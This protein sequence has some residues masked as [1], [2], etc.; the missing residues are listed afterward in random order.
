MLLHHQFGRTP[1]GAH[2]VGELPGVGHRRRQAHQPNVGRGVDDHLL[3]HRPPG[4]VLQI[5]HLVQHHRLHF[6]QVVPHVDHV[7]QHF[8]GHHHHR[9]APV[10]RVVP[11]EQTHPFASVNPAQ[12]AEFLVGQGFDGSGVK[13]PPAPAQAH[14]HRPFRHQS[15]ARP[16]G[17]RHHHRRPPFHRLQSRCLKRIGR[18]G[19]GIQKSGQAAAV[20]F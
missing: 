4:P 19:K 16:G 17:G 20:I 6:G 5:M 18:M 9:G 2:P 10:H 14:L 8:G 7:A 3:P 12:V 13:S 15:L 1:P 11:G